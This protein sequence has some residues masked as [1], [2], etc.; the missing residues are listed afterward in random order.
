MA[1]THGRGPQR[2]GAPGQNRTTTEKVRSL[3]EP[4]HF[5]EESRH[6]RRLS[7]P[8]RSADR[9]R[10][11][12][13]IST[14]ASPATS[15]S[16]ARARASSTDC[17]IHL[18]T[19]IVLQ[20]DGPRAGRA[21]EL[22]PRRRAHREAAPPLQA[23]A[24]GPS[25][26]TGARRRRRRPSYVIAALDEDEEVGADYNPTIIAED[27]QHLETMT[28]GAS[29]DGDG[30]RRSPVVV[31]RN[32]GHG[33][34]NV[35]YRRNDGHI[36]WIDPSLTSESD[37]RKTLSRARAPRVAARAPDIDHWTANDG[38]ERSHRA[39]R[40]P[41]A[42]LKANSKKQAIQALAEKAAELTGTRRARDLRDA[43]PAREARLDRR[44]RR[45]RHPARQARQARPHLRPVRP[46]AE[47][48]RLRGARRPAG[49]SHLPAA[50]R[51]KAPAPITSRR[52]PASRGTCASRAS[53]ESSAPRPTRRRSTR[54]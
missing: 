31:F 38:P 6:R 47:A 40:H 5:R 28:V 26:A 48:D 33:G 27:D 2:R 15:R 54:C 41:S 46:A 42:S 30:P 1:P 8:C 39:R 49:R 21:P 14:A 45:H 10:G 52:S 53:R 29:G 34:I 51:R 24:E 32:A 19:G 50:R 25:R 44:R 11:R 16:S 7:R 20:A 13:N 35:V 36:G 18:D 43:A 9:R 22:R 3:H 23:P 4:A 37:F 12:A 17:A